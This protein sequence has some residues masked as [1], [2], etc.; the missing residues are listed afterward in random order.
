MQKI[1]IK[2]TRLYDEAEERLLELKL[3]HES[4]EEKLK[5]KPNGKI[6]IKKHKNSV[7]FYLRKV[8]GERLGTYISKKN[9][10]MITQY[11]EK[12]YYEKSLLELDKEIAILESVVNEV[13]E[14]QPCLYSVFEA[15]HPDARRF[16]TPIAC[17]DETYVNMWISRPYEKKPIGDAALDRY[18]DKGEHVRSKSEENIANALYKAGIPY[19]YECPLKLKSGA[20]IHPDFTILDVKNRKEVYWEHR[21]MMDDREYAKDSVRRIKEMNANGI[22]LGDRLIITEETSNQQLGTN[23]IKSIINHYFGSN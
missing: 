8:P 23:E 1:S 4:I 19:K 5:N 22:Y 11:L 3:L 10:M 16:I 21:G 6:V 14:A 20:I 9:Q 7:Q 15:Y 17:S 13:N 18:T 2:P 12:Q